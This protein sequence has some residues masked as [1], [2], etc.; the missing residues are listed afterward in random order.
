MHDDTFQFRT[1]NWILTKEA[2]MYSTIPV[3]P[4]LK[5]KK[6]APSTSQLHLYSALG[7]TAKHPNNSPVP[8]HPLHKH[9]TSV[10]VDLSLPPHSTWPAID[11]LEVPV[12]DVSPSTSPTHT[13][14]PLF[15]AHHHSNSNALLAP[16]TSSN[17]VPPSQAETRIFP[18]P[19][20][21]RAAVRGLGWA[22]DRELGVLLLRLVGPT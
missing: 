19:S 21:S 6:K 1:P 22:G 11:R 5:P 13:D 2:R 7:Q 12:L 16:T 18:P 20:A 17:P 4:S 3:P 14:K 10:T 8:H 9:P 15:P